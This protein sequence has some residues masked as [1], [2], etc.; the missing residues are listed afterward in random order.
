MVWKKFMKDVKIE[1]SAR[2]V[3]LSEEDFKKL[4]GE[5]ARLDKLND[6]SQP[7]EFACKETVTLI[8]EKGKIKN[9]R[10][11]GPFRGKTQVEI[12]LTD[13]RFLGVEPPVR[14]SGDTDESEGITILGTLDCR[15]KIK[16]G[17]ILA[18]RHLHASRGEAMDLKLVSGEKVSVETFGRRALIFHEVIVRVAPNYKLAFHIDTDEANAARVKTGDKGNLITYH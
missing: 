11:L 6:L 14:L 12:S 18:K 13:A 17:V 4:F 3:H 15:I 9:V 16:E 7:G 8:G 10:V 5:R 1:V 2:H